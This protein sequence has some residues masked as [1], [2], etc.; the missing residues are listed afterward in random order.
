[1]RKGKV[2][3]NGIKQKPEFNP[4]ISKF[5]ISINTRRV[6]CVKEMDHLILSW[7]MMVVYGRFKLSSVPQ[8]LPT[9]CSLHQF[10]FP[11]ARLLWRGYFACCQVDKQRFFSGWSQDEQLPTHV[12]HSPYIHTNS[13]FPFRMDSRIILCSTVHH[14]RKINSS[15]IRSFNVCAAAHNT[16]IQTVELHNAP[17]QAVWR[18]L[19]LFAC[20]NTNRNSLWKCS[21][22]LIKT[23]Q[24]ECTH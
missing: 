11:H 2:T 19:N 20:H 21:N 6:H 1:M 8:V 16:L 23:F 3:K 22:I 10:K 24:S 9:S 12:S 5:D 18:I 7:L 13:A 15:A 4:G 14:S 17:L